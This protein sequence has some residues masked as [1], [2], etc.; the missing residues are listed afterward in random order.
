MS[1]Y[2]RHIV[3]RC[4]CCLHHSIVPPWT[5]PVRGEEVS[6]AENLRGSGERSRRYAGP[7][8][9]SSNPRAARDICEGRLKSET[10]C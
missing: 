4:Y 8:H 3:C 1:E 9:C 10:V 2:F 5:I 6:I 7:Y